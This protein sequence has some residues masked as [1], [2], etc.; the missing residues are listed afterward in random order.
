MGHPVHDGFQSSTS[1][2]SDWTPLTQA[3]D[4]VSVR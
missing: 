4:N 3:L 1:D 2:A